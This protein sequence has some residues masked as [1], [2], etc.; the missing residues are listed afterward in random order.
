[1]CN[2]KIIGKIDLP[3][4]DTVKIYTCE[5]CKQTLEAKHF[6]DTSWGNYICDEC[7]YDDTEGER[8]F[9]KAQLSSGEI[10]EDERIIYG[11]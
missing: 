7:I 4:N 3:V 5:R 8:A 11:L 1:M 6:P 9:I 10:S 2:V